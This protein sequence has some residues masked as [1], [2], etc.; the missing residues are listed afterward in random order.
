MELLLIIL[1]LLLILYIVYKFI[2]MILIDFVKLIKFFFVKKKVENYFN[3]NLNNIE[4]KDV[5]HFFDDGVK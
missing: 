3:N 1:L 5:K 2:R 4:F